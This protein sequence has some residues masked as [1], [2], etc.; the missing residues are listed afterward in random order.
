MSDFVIVGAG[1]A[2]L[3]TALAL[4]ENSP[5]LPKITVVSDHD[6]YTFP[7]QPEYTSAWAGAHFRPFPSKS[8]A[9][10]KDFSLSRVTYK[11]F[12]RLVKD[13]PESS[14]RFIRGIDYLEAPDKLY[15][16]LAPGYTEGLENFSI[17][18]QERLV[19]DS[20]MGAV[21]DTF[22]LNPP[23]YL[24]FLYRQLKFK[25]MVEFAT[26]KLEKLKDARKFGSPGAI[27]INCT[28]NG[29]KWEGGHDENY[30]FVR[31]QTLTVRPPQNSEIQEYTM[32]HQLK[33]NT[34]TFYIPRPLDGGVILG[35]T[36]QP[37][38][39]FRGVRLA[40]T[41]ALLNRAAK[42]F[43]QL[44][45]ISKN[46]K[47]YFDVVGTNVGFRPYVKGGVNFSV[48]LHEGTTVINGYGLGGSGY[49][50]SYGVAMKIVEIINKR[51]SKL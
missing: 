41:E 9:E 15:Q 7:P 5:T 38:D 21:Y 37:D 34:W 47:R 20:L 19:K 46:G 3:T 35:G 44:M 10:L 27:I 30:T 25:Y 17:L 11:R 2:G 45:K 29:L 6:P 31:G 8:E 40:D 48:D 26:E 49:E 50:F 33:D 24:Q 22:V 1:V 32:T 4:S 13:H 28:G 51:T 14:I 42:I 36:K 23:V 43:P 39:L 16:D 18:P 12:K